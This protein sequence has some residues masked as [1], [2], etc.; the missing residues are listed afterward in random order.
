MKECL[1]AVFY[2]QQ[3]DVKVAILDEYFLSIYN[4]F[5]AELLQK[6]IELA[7]NGEEDYN[8]HSLANELNVSRRTLLRLFRKHL[9]SSTKEYLKMIKFRK[10]VKVYQESLK[11]MNLSDLTYQ[12]N[13]NDQSEFIHHFKSLTGFSPKSFFQNLNTISNQGTYWTLAQKNEAVPNSQ[14]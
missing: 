9:N 6:A 7:L 10:A 12:V 3:L 13:Y 1:D 8:V 11:S 4:S 14:F 2:E 5:D